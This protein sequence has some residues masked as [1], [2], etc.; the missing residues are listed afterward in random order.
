MELRELKNQG[1]GAFL[2]LNAIFVVTISVLQLN[3]DTLSVPWPCGK[4]ERGE[5]EI[6]R[7]YPE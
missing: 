4:R 3:M 7:I 1:A 2:M 5:Q 6:E